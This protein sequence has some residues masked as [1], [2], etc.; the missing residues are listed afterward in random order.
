VSGAGARR[1]GS[2]FERELVAYLREHGFPH[3]SRAYGA[4]RPDD[5]G[6]IAGVP[7]TVQAKAV[8]EM[9]LGETL[10]IVGV[11]ASRR[12]V[13]AWPIAIFKRRQRPVGEAFVV[14]TLDTFTGLYTARERPDTPL[15]LLDG[16]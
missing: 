14:M 1:K 9:R 10:D 3:A 13:W 6:D 12:A 8:K 7:W 5:Q 2:D 16:S 15:E 11:Q 4:G